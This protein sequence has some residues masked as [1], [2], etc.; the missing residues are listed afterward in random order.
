M[1]TA[2][3]PANQVGAFMDALE[4]HAT[5]GARLHP[6]ATPRERGLLV[7]ALKL[8]RTPAAM[9]EADVQAMRAAGLDDAEIL[10]ANQVTSYFAYANRLADGLGI[11]L[12]PWHQG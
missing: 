1:T 6:H 12:E 11:E 8:T 4:A 10:D 3:F 9:S 5:T 7:Y 2:E